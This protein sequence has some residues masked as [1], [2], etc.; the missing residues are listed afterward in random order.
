MPPLS[1][2]GPVRVLSSRGLRFTGLVLDANNERLL[3]TNETLDYLAI[4]LKYLD[5]VE[6]EARRPVALGD[7]KEQVKVDATRFS[8]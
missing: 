5:G 7:S 2:T 1:A 8:G 6:A 4:Q 3:T